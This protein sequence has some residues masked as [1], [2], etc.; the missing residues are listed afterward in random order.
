MAGDS[1]AVL[2]GEGPDAPIAALS[3]AG[4]RVGGTVAR[5][6]TVDDDISGTG[7]VPEGWTVDRSVDCLS[8]GPLPAF[9]AGVASVPHRALTGRRTG[10]QIETPKSDDLQPEMEKRHGW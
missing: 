2:T 9:F 1:M 4:H 8:G 5:D 7:E 6:R 10:V 3:I